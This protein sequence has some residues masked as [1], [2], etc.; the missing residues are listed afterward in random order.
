M[1]IA[2]IYSIYS[3]KAYIKVIPWKRVEE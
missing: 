2:L 1:L 3:R